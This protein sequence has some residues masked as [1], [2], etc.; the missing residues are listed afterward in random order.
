[1][2]Q[3]FVKIENITTPR[4][5]YEVFNFNEDTVTPQELLSQIRERYTFKE[6]NRIRLELWT[7]PLGSQESECIDWYKIIPDKFNTFWVRGYIMDE[8]IDK[9]D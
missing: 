1:M 9:R 5:S 6:T 2:R 4:K 8:K 3:F 7:G